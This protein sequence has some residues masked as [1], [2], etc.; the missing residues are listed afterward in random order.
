[1]HPTS[2]LRRH[3]SICY[4]CDR[5]CCRCGGGGGQPP[6][7]I[8]GAVLVD[9]G[10]ST[11]PLKFSEVT[12]HVTNSLSASSTGSRPTQ[13]YFRQAPIVFTTVF[14][15][16]HRLRAG[17]ARSGYATVRIPSYL[18]CASESLVFCLQSMSVLILA[19]IRRRLL[20]FCRVIHRTVAQ[21]HSTTTT[22][23]LLRTCLDIIDYCQAR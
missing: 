12:D 6:P 8:F 18:I 2:Y 23:C 15:N 20:R 10:L 7:C 5:R 21:S 19:Q 22:T 1:M 16:L 11:F 13:P 17:A 3:P 14:P 4:R 9:H